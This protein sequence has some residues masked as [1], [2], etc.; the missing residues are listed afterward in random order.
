METFRIWQ[1]WSY[2]YNFIIEVTKIV[3]WFEKFYGGK[4]CK[5]SGTYTTATDQTPTVVGAGSSSGYI[6][7]AGDIVLNSRTGERMVVGTVAATTIQLHVRSYGSTAAAAGLDGDGLY[8]IGN[9]NEENSGARNLNS[10]RSAEESNYTQIFKKT[11]GVSGT[12]KEA[13]LYG[14]KDLPLERAIAATE[15]ALDKTLSPVSV[16]A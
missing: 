11:I 8:I 6:F 9:V 3:K 7:T 15:H 5:V 12:E 1:K 2:L 10:T 13:T 14:P 4:Y 16:M